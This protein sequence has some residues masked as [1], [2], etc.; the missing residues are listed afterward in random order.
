VN[1]LRRGDNDD[2][3]DDD[4][5]EYNQTTS[6][7]KCGLLLNTVNALLAKESFWAIFHS[8]FLPK[9][10]PNDSVQSVC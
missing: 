5:R 3:D 9:K 8:H 1:I 10:F 2:D 4:A 7:Q 6:L